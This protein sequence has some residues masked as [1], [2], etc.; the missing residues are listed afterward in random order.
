M[1]LGCEAMLVREPAEVDFSWV[2]HVCAPVL[3]GAV[4]PGP[5]LAVEPYVI[6]NVLPAASVSEAT[7]IVLA[8]TV[9]VP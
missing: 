5:P 1:M 7:V 6:V 8:E 3:D 9:S 2:V 4:A